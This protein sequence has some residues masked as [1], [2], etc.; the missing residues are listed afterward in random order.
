MGFADSHDW[1]RDSQLVID[2]ARSEDGTFGT[3]A[4]SVSNQITIHYSN[5]DLIWGNGFPVS[6][7]GAGAFQI[8]TAALYKELTGN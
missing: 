3:L 8:A 4:K 6:R 5:P 2:L 7:F 1:G